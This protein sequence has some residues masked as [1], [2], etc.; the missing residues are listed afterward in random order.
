NNFNVSVAVSDEFIRTLQ[1]GRDWALVHKAKPGAALVAQGAHARG[2][3]TWVYRTLPAQQ[4]RDAVMRS[5]YDFAEP[6]ILFVDTINRENNLRYAERIT[7]TNPCGEQPLPPYGC[8]D[9]G[10]IILTKFVRHP[11]GFGGTPAFDFDA[12]AHS[13]AVQVR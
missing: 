11:F 7:A 9:L 12:F 8:C 3:G 1:A 5:A 2:D 6:G 13:A 10:P 4:L